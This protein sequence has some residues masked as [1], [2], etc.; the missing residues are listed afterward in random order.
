MPCL[1]I[2]SLLLIGKGNYWTLDPASEDMFDNGSFLRR[3]KRY[4]RTVR[5]MSPYAP[6]RPT[7]NMSNMPYHPSFT[8]MLRAQ[9]LGLMGGP[10]HLPQLPSF[11][12]MFT[13]QPSSSA[14]N[15]A[16]SSLIKESAKDVPHKFSIE[17]II[18]RNE[19]LTERITQ[20]Q[21][22]FLAAAAASAGFPL[23][24]H[25]FPL[26]RFRQMPFQPN[27]LNLS[28]YHQ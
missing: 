18:G 3:R 27:K 20:Q 17:S 15:D 23:F 8:H 11:P 1:E 24:S 22:Q 25:H 16:M 14:K 12:P 13:A 9:G 10:L 6:T 21:N 26:D 4:K 5:D 19:S 2:S 7:D 28:A